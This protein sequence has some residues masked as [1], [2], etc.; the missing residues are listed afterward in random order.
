MAGEYVRRWR[1]VSKDGEICPRVVERRIESFRNTRSDRC[2]TSLR[3]GSRRFI[4]D[5]DVDYALRQDMGENFRKRIATISTLGTTFD[6]VYGEWPGVNKEGNECPVVIC[7]HGV[8]ATYGAYRPIGIR[9]A[10]RGYRVLAVNFPG[11]GYTEIDARSAY[12][13]TTQHK[14]QIVKAFIFAL[15]LERVAM[16]IGHS[17]GCMVVTSMA[18]DPEL[19][20]VV[21][22][23]GMICGT[24]TTPNRIQKRYTTI[25]YLPYLLYRAVFLPIIGPVILHVVSNMVYRLGFRARTREAQ[26]LALHETAMQR[27]DLFIEDLKELRRKQFPLLLFYCLD[28]TVFEPDK[29]RVTIATLGITEDGVKTYDADNRSLEAFLEGTLQRVVCCERGSHRLHFT[30]PELTV[31]E[32]VSFLSVLQKEEAG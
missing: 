11:N 14:A 2:H 18:A 19:D 28:D 9:I 24:G 22:S 26:V 31:N 13:Y 27:F 6:M 21:Q 10:A 12:D 8:P 17:S 32:L 3:R 23:V 7:V 15:T 1:N 20:G 30:Q 16:V 4:L 29:T 5:G 25:P